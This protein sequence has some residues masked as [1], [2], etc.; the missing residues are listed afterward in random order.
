[1]KVQ[2]GV[3]KAPEPE[4]VKTGFLAV[5]LVLLV[6]LTLFHWQ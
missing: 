6:M 3:M 4:P 1:M 2:A 5:E